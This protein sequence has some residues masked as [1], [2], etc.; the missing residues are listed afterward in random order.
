VANFFSVDSSDRP[1]STELL[2]LCR[3]AGCV[4]PTT[5]FFFQMLLPAACPSLSLSSTCFPSLFPTPVR[6]AVLGF[7]IE[8]V[9][10]LK[11]AAACS[12]HSPPIRLR[13]SKASLAPPGSVS[14]CC[15]N[16]PFE[17]SGVLQECVLLFRFSPLPTFFLVVGCF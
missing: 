1:A 2:F 10:Y 17:I 15:V 5:L 4:P 13:I 6:A 11:Y 14:S 8:T 9:G 7:R 3:L 12:V 16:I